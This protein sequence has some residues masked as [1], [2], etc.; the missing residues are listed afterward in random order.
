MKNCKSCGKSL[1]KTA[2]VCPE[3]GRDQRS[4]F[5]RHKILTFILVLFILGG[6]GS[7][8]PDSDPPI[9]S[10]SSAIGSDSNVS[11]NSTTPEASSPKATTPS[12]ELISHETQSDQFSRY[13]VGQIKNNSNKKMSYAQIEIN[14]YDDNGNQVGSALDNINNLE[15]GGTWNFKAIILEDSCTKYKIADISGF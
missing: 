15:A 4:W 10:Q 13:V 5:S 7:F 14:L 12:L 11:E 1:D 2:K 6:I 3:C 8:L 9:D